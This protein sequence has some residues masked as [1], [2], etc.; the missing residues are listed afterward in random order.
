MTKLNP[1]IEMSLSNIARLNCTVL[2]SRPPVSNVSSFY[3]IF[4]R[5]Q[6]RRQKK[7][8]ALRWAAHDLAPNVSAPPPPDIAGEFNV[9]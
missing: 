4:A 6:T 3:N 5:S 1:A 8:N 7:L 9:S 2:Y